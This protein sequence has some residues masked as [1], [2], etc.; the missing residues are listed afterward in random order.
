MS[1]AF[2]LLLTFVCSISPR[3]G[4][5]RAV[6]KAAN[7][8]RLR[9]DRKRPALRAGA[10]L[11]AHHSQDPRA[12]FCGRGTRPR[13]CRTARARAEGRLP[14]AADHREIGGRGRAGGARGARCRHAFFPDRRAG[15]ELQA[16]R[17]SRA[18]PRRDFCST[19][20]SRRIRC[21]AICARPNSSMSIRAAH[22]SWTGSRNSSSRANGATFWCSKAP[23]PPTRR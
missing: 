10:R 14:L 5:G 18:R 23:R 17:R 8:Y 1:L 20:R 11:R 7:Q 4:A 6:G 12:P 19:S 13:R 3:I 21:A 22:S 9:R 2:L 15:G 16:A